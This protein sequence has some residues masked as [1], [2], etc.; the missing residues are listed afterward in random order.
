MHLLM[1]NSYSGRSTLVR[2]CPMKSLSSV[3]LSVRLLVCLSLNFLKIGSLVFSYIVHDDSWLTKPYFWKKIFSGLNL[4]VK[5]L[6]QV[7]YEFFFAIILG[8][9]WNLGLTWVWWVFIEIVYDDILWQWITS[10]SGKTHESLLGDPD[11][12]RKSQNQAQN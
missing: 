6:Y 12:G 2:Q 11:L 10:I 9:I 1:L 4:G 3:R 8:L 7:L 5:D